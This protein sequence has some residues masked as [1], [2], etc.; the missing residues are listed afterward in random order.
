MSNNDDT[1]ADVHPQDWKLLAEK[2]KKQRGWW[3][4]NREPKQIADVVAQ[5]IQ[6]KGYAQVQ[7]AGA[8]DAAW[9]EAIGERF[10]PLTAPGN[11]R[12]GVL[13]V[14]VANS[15]LMQE[16]GFEKER[17]LRALQTAMPEAGLKQIRFKVGKV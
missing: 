6:R 1:P 14:M 11:L 7:A 9:K 16:L 10:A 5:L 15:L 3:Y 8:W 12:R 13:E 4:H 2:R 17:L